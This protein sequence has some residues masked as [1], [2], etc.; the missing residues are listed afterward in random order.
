MALFRPEN[1]TKS[2]RNRRIYAIY[3]IAYTLVDFSAAFLFLIGSVLF[4]YKSL[5]TPAIWCFVIG[6]VFF[7][8]KPTLR[9]IREFQYLAEGDWEDLAERAER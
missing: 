8:L 1:R 2:Q 4:F 7:A 9:V 5:E 6:S 3:E